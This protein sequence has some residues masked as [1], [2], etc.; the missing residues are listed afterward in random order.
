M[1]GRVI[2]VCIISGV[3]GIAEFENSWC[4]GNKGSFISH[5]DHLFA[6][7]GMLTTAS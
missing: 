7:L 4:R 6:K 1:G 5:D 3:G 2:N